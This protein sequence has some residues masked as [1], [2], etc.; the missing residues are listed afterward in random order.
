MVDAAHVAF[1]IVAAEAV[2]ITGL[3]YGHGG[4]GERPGVGHIR[5]AMMDWFTLPRLQLRPAWEEQIA[6][7]SE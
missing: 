5:D 1:L 3:R 6:G 4:A 2:G 7:P